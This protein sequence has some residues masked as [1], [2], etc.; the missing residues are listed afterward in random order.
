M[1]RFY[2]TY[3]KINYSQKR[4]LESTDNKENNDAP[5]V[6]KVKA[7]LLFVVA[8]QF[9]KDN[10]NIDAAPTMWQKWLRDHDRMRF[11]YQTNV[12]NPRPSGLCK[13]HCVVVE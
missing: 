13:K 7:G 5:E 11:A 1:A 4:K 6:K 2:D 8:K 9:V 12:W 10:Y 3:F